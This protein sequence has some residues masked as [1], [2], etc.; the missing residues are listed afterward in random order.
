VAAVAVAAEAEGEEIGCRAE[1]P[2]GTSVVS[3]LSSRTT[4]MKT[5]SAIIQP[6]RTETVSRKVRRSSTKRFTKIAKA[7]IGPSR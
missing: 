3:A 1:L 5:C 4:E 2:D 6:S 7:N